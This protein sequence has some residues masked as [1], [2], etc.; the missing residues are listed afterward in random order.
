MPSQNKDNKIREI[1]RELSAKFFQR[2]SNHKSLI[3]ITDVEL[4]SRNSKAII[5][6]TVLPVDQEEAAIDFM[7][8]Q[9]SELRSY[10]GANARLMRVPFLDV[11]IDKGEKNRQLID[12]IE[13][14]L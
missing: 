2:E 7:K 11:A 9:L 13:K 12:E 3:T 4:R 8:R 10:I 14:K 5:L 6:C 1:I